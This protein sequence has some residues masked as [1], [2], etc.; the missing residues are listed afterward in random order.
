MTAPTLIE[1]PDL[2]QGSEEWHA[3][4]RGI[5]TASVVGQLVTTKTL[6][7]A[8]NDVSRGLTRLLVAERITGWT[9]PMYV[10]DD[11]LRGIEDEPK[12]RDKYSEHYA[13][14]TEIGFMIREDHDVK[15]GYSPDGLIGD[16]GLIEVKSRRQKKHLE[17][18]LADEPPAE[19]LAQMQC[20]LLVSGRE[21]CDYISYC[22]G[23]PLWV[24]RVFPDQRWFDAI[25]AAVDAFEENA[26]EMIRLY[27]ERTVGLP[28]TERTV[29]ME[30]VI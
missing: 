1:L 5:V 10:S 25:L 14:V 30:M 6:K 11:M 18:I 4:R 20:G 3:Q 17:T 15:I 27:D 29:E 23:M 9:D 13:P 12:A 28:M 24:K 19:N 2:E 7:P 21:W 8:S 26:A 16:D 22:G